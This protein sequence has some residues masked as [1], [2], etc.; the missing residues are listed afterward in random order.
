MAKYTITHA[1]GHTTEQ[2]LYGKHKARYAK[3]AWW[4]TVD[5]PACYGQAKRDAE[6][7]R[8]DKATQCKDKLAKEGIVIGAKLLNKMTD[9]RVSITDI[10]YID[11]RHTVTITIVNDD[12]TTKTGYL[13]VAGLQDAIKEGKVTIEEGI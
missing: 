5:C 7:R 9:T 4:E 12:L 11:D 3:I 8:Q 1:C 6:Q 2:Q 10:D 13:P